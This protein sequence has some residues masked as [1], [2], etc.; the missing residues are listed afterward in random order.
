MVNVSVHF[1]ANRTKAQQDFTKVL[2]FETMLANV[3]NYHLITFI[4][5][6]KLLIFLSLLNDRLQY[7]KKKEEIPIN[8]I[9]Q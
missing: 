1:G 3:S 7:R 6:A 5:R 8:F 9:I 2:I 4:S